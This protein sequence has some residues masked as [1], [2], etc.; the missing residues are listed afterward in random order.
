MVR[1]YTAETPLSVAKSRVPPAN[2]NLDS[3]TALSSQY[4]HT[5][6]DIKEALRVIQFRLDDKDRQINVLQKN[7]ADMLTR[8]D[9]RDMQMVMLQQSNANAQNR[10]DDKDRQITMLQQ[11]DAALENTIADVQNENSELRGTV[12]SLKTHC[13]ALRTKTIMLL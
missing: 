8:L 5:D 1:C 7:D 11:K 9:D 13:A 6:H 12:E 3:D 2:V 4:G 10:L